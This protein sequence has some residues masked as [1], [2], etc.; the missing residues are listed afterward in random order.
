MTMNMLLV[1]TRANIISQPS[2]DTNSHL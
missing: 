2:S 1:T